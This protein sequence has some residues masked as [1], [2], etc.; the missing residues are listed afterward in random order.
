MKVLGVLTALEISKKQQYIFKTNRLKENI[1]ASSI[2]EY[3]TEKLPLNMCSQ[4]QGKLINNGGGRSIFY[5]EESNNAI[6]FNRA[7]TTKML[8]DYPGLEFFVS[9]EQFDQSKDRIINKIDLLFSKVELKK[10]DR[11]YYATISDFGLSE[12]CHSTRL[13]AIEVDYNGEYLSAEVIAKIKAANIEYE[14]NKKLAYAS[15]VEDLGLSANEKSYVAIT[16]IDGNRMGKRIQALKEEYVTKYENGSITNVNDSY[17]ASLNDFSEIIKNAFDKAF[18]KLVTA[19]NENKENLMKNGMKLT[20][21]IIPIRKIILAG[22]DVCYL[23][24]ARVALECSRIFIEELEKHKL[25]NEK[26]TACAGIAIVKNKFPFYKAYNLAEELCANAKLTILEGEMESKV[27]WQI[28]QG[29]F[30]TSLDEIRANTYEADDG[31]KL[32]M[33]PLSLSKGVEGQSLYEYFLMDMINI[34]SDI[35]A[36]SKIKG[37]I[38]CIKQGKSATDININVNRL[39]SLIGSHRQGEMSAFID[40]KCVI[41]DA[42][43]SIDLFIPMKEEMIK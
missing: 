15:S 9:L 27:D 31:N 42:I 3:T 11:Y 28:I 30:N 24:D 8:K 41:F 19:F 38:P 1:G 13:P 36:R 25:M 26:I 20:D 35:I 5:F 34:N 32:L 37:L 40:G 18:E 33:R 12:K 23:T 2:I 4:F 10:A 14:E 43:E 17:L 22:D 6:E 39:Y 7:I 29:D 21:G 16:H